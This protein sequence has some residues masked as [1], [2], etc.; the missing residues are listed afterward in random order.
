[1]TIKTHIDFA[2]HI[3]NR[4]RRLVELDPSEGTVKDRRPND[5]A[6]AGILYCLDQSGAQGQDAF[7]RERGPQRIRP[8][9]IGLMFHATQ[10]QGIC[11][12]TVEMDLWRRIDQFATPQVEWAALTMPGGPAIVPGQDTPRLLNVTVDMDLADL[13]GSAGRLEAALNQE[14]SRLAPHCAHLVAPGQ[15]ATMNAA[16]AAQVTAQVRPNDDPAVPHTVVINVTNATPMLANK[17]RE[18]A[19][20]HFFRPRITLDF[21]G[22]ES[23]VPKQPPRRE[24]SGNP[25]RAAPLQLGTALGASAYT[26]PT[27]HILQ[28]CVVPQTVQYKMKQV[29]G[30]PGTKLADLVAD[31]I[32]NVTKF[33]AA[34]EAYKPTWRTIEAQLGPLMSPQQLQEFHRDEASFHEEINLM[35][36]TLHGLQSDPHVLSAFKATFMTMEAMNATR[37]A[38][39]PKSPRNHFDSFRPFQ[40]GYVLTAIPDILARSGARHR[41]DAAWRAR[42]DLIF[43]PTGGGKTEAFQTVTVFNAFLDRLQG[44]NIGITAWLRFALRALTVD[45]TNRLYEVVHHAEEIRQ[46]LRIGSEPFRLGLLVGASY[47]PSEIIR[48]DKP[49][50]K[51]VDVVKRNIQDD[52]GHYA[53]VS[54]CPKCYGPIENQWIESEW[55]LASVC[56][57]NGCVGRLNVLLVDDEIRRRPCSFVVG[58][59]DKITGVGLTRRF[60]PLLRSPHWVCPKHGASAPKKGTPA[61]CGLK[62]DGECGERMVKMPRVEDWGPGIVI[63]DEVHL[64]EEELAAFTAQYESC[65]RYIQRRAG[66]PGP[67]TI[68]A[69]ATVAGFVKHV[70]ELVD[71][72]PRLFPSRSPTVDEGFWYS[73]DVT[74]V[75]RQV[76]AILPHGKT[77]EDAMTDTIVAFTRVKATM[78]DPAHALGIDNIANAGDFGY[79]AWTPQTRKDLIRPYATNFIYVIARHAG[80]RIKGTMDEQVADRLRTFGLPAPRVPEMISSGL[81]A[82]Q[83]SALLKELSDEANVLWDDVIATR[84][85]AEGLDNPF[86]NC[87][88]MNGHP[89][90]VNEDTQVNGRSG[91]RY[92]GI[93]WRVFHPIMERD[94]NHYTFFWDYEASRDLLIEPSSINRHAMRSVNHTMPGILMALLFNSDLDRS[95]VQQAHKP[96]G[97][98]AIINDPGMQVE[99]PNAVAQ[100]YVLDPTLHPHFTQHATNL[101]EHHK[102]IIRQPNNGSWTNELFTRRPMMSLRDIDAGIPFWFDMSAYP[103]GRGQDIRNR[104]R[105]ATEMRRGRSTVIFNH[106][107][108]SLYRHATGAIVQTTRIGEDRGVNIMKTLDLDSLLPRLRRY[109]NLDDYLRLRLQQG[110]QIHR[111]IDLVRPGSLEFRVMPTIFVCKA[112]HVH[113]RDWPDN[114][115]ATTPCCNAT[116]SPATSYQMPV[117]AVHQNGSL[118]TLNVTACPGCQTNGPRRLDKSSPL[119]AGPTYW[120]WVCLQ[121]G[122]LDGITRRNWVTV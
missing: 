77:Q 117:V 7:E 8:C 73:R 28:T 112:C 101:L 114:L 58:T 34:V 93:V 82:P 96:G 25:R 89:R 80:D 104:M 38:A 57:R 98:L 22:I 48:H 97:A 3:V 75:Q 29:T 61:K 43:F 54:T 11:K 20:E 44:K 119:G 81:E 91:R 69:S 103:G 1:M 39:G 84:S 13:N 17:D 62:T 116:V 4:V 83:L 95:N 52:P 64:L 94:R 87:L 30:L 49:D 118:D 108:G 115:R 12:A 41:K 35:K 66:L 100:I 21:K 9:R 27:K 56:P 36:Q 122:T 47:T 92:C 67:K 33:I 37:I 53:Y 102:S 18:F 50:E 85:I 106:L 68:L 70:K 42:A 32:T 109:L 76:A 113:W 110:G 5:A 78:M 46:R 55:H 105:L 59:I 120:Q 14:L 121:C 74:Q 15:P 63:L 2:E 111:F 90:R 79:P 88:I 26:D 107:P 65:V 6:P 45:Q 10:L 99:L 86:F 24:D 72:E 16:Y 60:L 40:L 23:T 71:D 31:P 51:N 19:T